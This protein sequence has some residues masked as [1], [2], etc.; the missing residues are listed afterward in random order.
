MS[1]DNFD[2][3]FGIAMRVRFDLEKIWDADTA[4]ESY[5]NSGKG[6]SVGQCYVSTLVLYTR[7]LNFSP[8]IARGAVLGKCESHYWIEVDGM[9]LDITADQF[10]DYSRVLFC[11]YRD[12]PEYVLKSYDT[13]FAR[14]M[15][16]YGRYAKQQCKRN[17]R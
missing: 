7:L 12:R 9:I 15:L 4:H 1:T 14:F 2:D 10:F 16:L 6:S 3:I 11:E 13:G 5:D 17:T 8:K